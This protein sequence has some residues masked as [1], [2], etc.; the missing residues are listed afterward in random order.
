M[1]A[2]WC[3]GFGADADD[4]R[5]GVGVG[6]TGLAGGAGASSCLSERVDT[7]LSV[8]EAALDDAERTGWSVYDEEEVDVDADGSMIL[9]GTRRRWGLG[10]DGGSSA[11]TINRTVITRYID[12]A[13]HTT[14]L[15]LLL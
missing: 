4:A 3:G 9:I 15:C 7:A 5:T 8:S 12:S 10:S 1:R 11:Y 13:I 14:H 6:G 2:C